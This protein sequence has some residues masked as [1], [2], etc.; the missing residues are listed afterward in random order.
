MSNKQT[1]QWIEEKQK[2]IIEAMEKGDT[3]KA[4]Q[5][6]RELLEYGYN[7]TEEMEIKE[8]INELN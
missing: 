3:E 1:D 5:I 7:L 6:R 4:D 2:K 8:V